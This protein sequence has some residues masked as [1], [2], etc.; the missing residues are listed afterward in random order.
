MYATTPR[1]GALA[2]GALWAVGLT[3]LRATDCGGA[4]TAERTRKVNPRRLTKIR[5]LSAL[6]GAASAV[7]CFGA[8][9][10]RADTATVKFQPATVNNVPSLRVTVTDISGNGNLGTYGSC[11]FNANPTVGTMNVLQDIQTPMAPLY[12]EFQPNQG[13]SKS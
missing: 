6:G 10:A 7:L 1:Q 11:T 4:A 9:T 13:A 5:I 3:T 8:G 12:Q 2:W